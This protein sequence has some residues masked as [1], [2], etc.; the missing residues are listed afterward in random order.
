MK[1]IVTIALVMIF[2]GAIPISCNIVGGSCGFGNGK[3][4][5]Y[6]IASFGLRTTN[7]MNEEIDTTKAYSYDAIYKAL[8]VARMQVVTLKAFNTN[9]FINTV[10]AC[11]PLPPTAVDRFQEIKIT[12]LTDIALVD[13]NDQ[14]ATGQDITERFV[15]ARSYNNDFQSI[16]NF[17][18][19]NLVIGAEEFFK[20]RLTKKPF[21]ETHLNLKFSILMTNGKTFEFDK[22]IMKVN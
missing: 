8:Y 6:T 5:N 20:I 18:K 22:Q 1:G 4:T 11:S 16:D 9:L 13:E 19:Q 14:I 15:L 17:I 21:K 2:I 7:S 12:S 10:S 3:V